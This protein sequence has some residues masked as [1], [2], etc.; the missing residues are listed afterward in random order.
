[1][2]VGHWGQSLGQ[3]RAQ[4]RTEVGQARARGQ[5]SDR[6]PVACGEQ[7]HNG[8]STR[9]EGLCPG[10]GPH[11]V[12]WAAVSRAERREACWVFRWGRP[13]REVGRSQ[14]S[15]AVHSKINGGGAG[16]IPG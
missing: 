3:A 1:M 16:L 6:Q 12:S 14:G 5:L 8:S 7:W 9:E 4:H 10:A 11:G 15:W 13:G 2:E